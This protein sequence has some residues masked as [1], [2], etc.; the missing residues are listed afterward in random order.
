MEEHLTDDSQAITGLV[1]RITDGLVGL[2]QAIRALPEIPAQVVNNLAQGLQTLTRMAE[3][4]SHPVVAQVVANEM[5]IE[6]LNRAMALMTA[7]G[8]T[9]SETVLAVHEY[10]HAIRELMDTLPTIISQMEHIRSLPLS[11]Q[12][13][14]DLV[15]SLLDVSNFLRVTFKHVC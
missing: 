13:H 4:E 11:N 2:E 12:I 10:E 8:E 1:R 9:A 6:D 15:T 3:Q 14:R 7:N 5:E